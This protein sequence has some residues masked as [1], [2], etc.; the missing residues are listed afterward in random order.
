MADGPDSKSLEDAILER[1]LEFDGKTTG[2]LEI[3]CQ[4]AGQDFSGFGRLLELA[5]GKDIR[6]QIAATWTIRKL[7]ELGAVLTAKDLKRFSKTAAAQ[8]AWES[9]LHMAQCIQFLGDGDLDTGTLAQTLQPWCDA[10]RPFLRAWALDGL[11][12]LALRDPDLKPRALELLA[13]GAEDPA[14][15]VRARVRNLR[16]TRIL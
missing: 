7:L 5:G 2:S 14:A 3:A 8:R 6:L 13:K 11:C 15:S 10:E 4:S 9:Q 12:R 1:I 16:E